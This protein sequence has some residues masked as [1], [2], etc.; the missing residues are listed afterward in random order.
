[1]Q[2]MKRALLPA[3]VFVTGGCV[4]VVEVVATRILA[5]YFGNTI[6]SVS[7]VISV[8]LA[9]LSVGYYLGG[10]TADKYPRLRLFFWL[11]VASGLSVLFLQ[12]LRKFLL[13]HTGYHLPLTTGPLIMSVTLFFVPSFVLGMLSPF[14]IALQQKRASKGQGV[15]TTAGEM[16]FFSTVGSIAGSLLAGFVL[17]PH[18]GITGIVIGV[19]V[20]LVLLGLVPLAVMGLGQKLVAIVALLLALGAV[21][22]AGSNTPH[23][24]IYNHDGTY[25]NVMVVD[26][27]YAGRA[28]R[29][30]LLDGNYSAAEYPGSGELVFDYTKYYTLYQPF[31][32]AARN[33]LVIGGGA[34]SI[35]EAYAQDLPDAQVD[36]DEIEPGL[37]AV[38]RHYF[39]LQ[40]NPRLHLYTADGRQQLHS[41]HGTYDVIFGDAYH[42][43][44]SIPAHLTTKEFFELAQSK[45]SPG[46][47]FI[48]N[49][50]G[51]LKQDGRNSLAMSEIRTMQQVF[52][53]VYVVAVRS[54]AFQGTQ[55]LIM[56]GVNG[57]TVLDPSAW[58]GSDSEALRTLPGHLVNL[59][60][61]DLRRY[62]VLTDDFAPVDNLITGNLPKR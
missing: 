43:L 4:L 7:S 47:V 15:G 51:S 48:A 44:Y 18:L 59:P 26:G 19:G 39:G 46:G 13:P 49:V 20:V 27:V 35:P 1:M 57:R 45:L 56:V 9:A 22:G 10:R 21:L 3:T 55:N 34:Y 40:D 37:P 5:P 8:V 16:F 30:L 54:P 61:Y 60:A 52:Q 24:V 25:E 31:V 38:A 23:S 58:S 14:A 32:P 12:V 2:F 17:I 33:V 28:T 6:F 11:V 53:Q 62:A 42:S 36:V 29:F 41:A 50:I